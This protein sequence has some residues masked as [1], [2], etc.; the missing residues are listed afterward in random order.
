MVGLTTIVLQTAC[1]GSIDGETP[2]L[3]PLEFLGQAP[4]S[5]MVLLLRTAFDDPDGDL[6][7][8]VLEVMVN[9]QSSGIGALD[10][11]PL[12]FENNLDLDDTSGVLDF[13]VEVALDSSSVPEGGALFKIGVRAVDAETHVSNTQEVTL[14]ITLQ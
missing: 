1:A 7:S 14:E 8:G 11:E 3:G 6:G 4:D 10:L 2:Y 5:P 12:F 9:D 13:V